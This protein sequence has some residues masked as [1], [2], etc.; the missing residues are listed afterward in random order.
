MVLP[1]HRFLRLLLPAA[2]AGCGSILIIPLYDAD[3]V[4]AR[5]P[6]LKGAVLTP[7]EIPPPSQDP[8]EPNWMSDP[9][10]ALSAGDSL[11]LQCDADPE[12][13]R[14]L[15]I[16]PDGFISLPRLG[17]LAA[18][19]KKVREFEQDLRKSLARF[20][21]SPEVRVLLPENHE[22][23][24]DV[25]GM[26][27]HQTAVS[28][29]VQFAPWLTGVI[30][31]A[32]NFSRLA[33]LAQILV[34]RPE[35]RKVIL[36]DLYALN[37]DGATDQNILLRNGDV[38]VVTEL[39]DPDVTPFAREW[40]LVDAFLSGRMDRAALVR[41]IRELPPPPRKPPP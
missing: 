27:N 23:V 15:T 38:V 19:G 24:V 7:A 35:L 10:R 37:T 5:F 22:V 36:C 9:E 3:P 39:Y 18:A 16:P 31:K 4:A 8:A 2:M 32:G 34:V 14:K 21:R 1:A 33:N 17:R 25:V 6:S 11:F 40:E 28:L 41:G 29:P 30:L 20:H 26:V 13:T 12:L